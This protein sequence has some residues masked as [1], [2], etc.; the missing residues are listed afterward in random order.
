MKSLI[1][2][3]LL[4]SVSAFAETGRELWHKSSAA[5]QAIILSYYRDFFAAASAAEATAEWKEKKTVFFRLISEAWA[6]APFD[7]IYAGWPSVRQGTCSSPTRSNPDYQ[8]GPCT[9]GQMQCQPLLFGAGLC[10]PIAT[11]VQRQSAYSNCTQAYGRADRSEQTVIAEIITN[12]KQAQLLTLLD[13]AD[14]I[15]ADGKQAGTGMCRKLKERLSLMRRLAASMVSLMD[16]VGA[17]VSGVPPQNCPA[18]PDDKVGPLTLVDIPT[19]VIP[20][21]ELEIPTVVE[22]SDDDEPE[23]IVEETIPVAEVPTSVFRSDRPRPDT[24]TGNDNIRHEGQTIRGVESRY[25]FP[26]YGGE[27]IPSGVVIKG[28]E[29]SPWYRTGN[30]ISPYMGRVF[31]FLSNDQSVAGTYLE[32]EDDVLSGCIEP[33]ETEERGDVCN[34][35]TRMVLLPRKTQPSVSVVNGDLQVMLPT[36]ETVT[37]DQQTLAVKS[38]AL[39][40]GEL[41][42]NP[43]RHQR[44]IPNVRYTGAGISIR[45]DH[46]YQIASS[47][48]GDQ[49]AEVAQNGR[50]CTIP[51]SRIWDS[52]GE[53]LFTNDV[54]FV[55][56]INRACPAR[57]GQAA[58]TLLP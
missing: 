50:V 5:D 46:R 58:F 56:M 15:C 48:L 10:V 9:S 17:V 26:C 21:I 49:E 30:K 38:G 42:L 40:E 3:A 57:A 27:R 44:K 29:N 51:R 7:C 54:K 53:V 52:E 34:W 6:D 32:F 28:N 1:L 4:L 24:C 2:S 14:R 19:T 33:G 55:E 47:A 23:T 16:R 35:K 8:P 20:E 13:L 37:M 25:L 18:V 31:R 12:G 43:S 39:E 36:G 11:K 41:D 22:E 45:V